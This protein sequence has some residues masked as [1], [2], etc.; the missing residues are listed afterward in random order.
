MPPSQRVKGLAGVGEEEPEHTVY[1]KIARA[2]DVA[3]T[4]EN[5]GSWPDDLAALRAAKTS[6]LILL[7]DLL[8]PPEDDQGYNGA[9]SGY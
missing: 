9:S 3:V 2:M 5:S 4:F 7:C 1:T 6:F 8:D